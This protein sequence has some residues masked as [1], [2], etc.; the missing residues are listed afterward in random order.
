MVTDGPN[1]GSGQNQE[2]AYAKQ[3]HKDI[4]IG[5]AAGLRDAE[6]YQKSHY[7]GRDAGKYYGYGR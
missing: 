3:H 7:Y 6:K 4:D 2:G 1:D 5:P